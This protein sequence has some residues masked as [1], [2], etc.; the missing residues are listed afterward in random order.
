MGLKVQFGKEEYEVQP[1]RIGRI[2]RKL[3]SALSLATQ[4]AG[5]ETPD[6][7]GS[8][9]YEGLKVFVPDL[10]PEWQIA[11]YMSKE[12]FDRRNDDG[13]EESEY[14]EHRDG[15][16]LTTE[17]ADLLG[18]IYR[19]NGGERLVK[20][21]GKFIDENT[22]K[23]QFRIMQTQMVT[24]KA[25]NQLPSFSAPSTESDPESSSTTPPSSPTETPIPE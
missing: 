9:L 17:I 24:K 22:V 7:V 12:D 18:A 21:L 19:I 8:Q 23:R 1:Q 25:S 14:D 20:L 11:G 2:R 15:S 5:G 4:A 6:D 13:F 3:G 16:P 10:A